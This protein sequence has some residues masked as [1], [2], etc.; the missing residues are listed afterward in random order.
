M[1]RTIHISLIA[2]LLAW[3]GSALAAL[4]ILEEVA[5]ASVADTT[6]PRHVAGQVVL[7]ECNGCEPTVWRVG[8]ATGYYVGM[9]TQ[10]VAL[11]DLLAAASSGQQEMIYI[12][13]K[14]GTDEVTRIVLSLKH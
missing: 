9:D 12:F 14:P 6:L 11:A 8:S 5:E 7:R 13:Y 1:L 3:S 10:P 2:M 4:D